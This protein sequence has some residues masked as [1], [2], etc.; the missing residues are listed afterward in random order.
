MG[1]YQLSTLSVSS[2]SSSAVLVTELRVKFRDYLVT[3]C[4]AFELLL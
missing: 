1:S 3:G 2:D 4:V